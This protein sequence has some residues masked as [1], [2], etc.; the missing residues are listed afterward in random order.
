MTLRHEGTVRGVGG[1]AIDEACATT[2]PGLF[3]AGDAASREDL[4]GAA[5]GGGGPN[6]T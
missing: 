3:A 5:T 2:V 1:L 6:S 4:V